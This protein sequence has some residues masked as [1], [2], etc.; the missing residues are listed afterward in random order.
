MEQVRKDAVNGFEGLKALHTE[1]LTDSGLHLGVGRVG[2]WWLNEERKER[3]SIK[4]E[5]VLQVCTK[6]Q[7]GCARMLLTAL[8]ERKGDERPPLSDFIEVRFPEKGLD[9]EVAVG[10]DVGGVVFVGVKKRET[11][12]EFADVCFGSC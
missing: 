10:W 4:V 1:L 3:E 8:H 11:M 12:E 9:V 7:I 5:Q 2:V 6:E